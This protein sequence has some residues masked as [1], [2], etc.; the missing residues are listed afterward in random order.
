MDTRRI[1]LLVALVATVAF[2]YL[3][4][5][6]AVKDGVTVLVVISFVVLALFAFGIIGALRHP[7]ED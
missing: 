1:V 5:A 3:T 7:P 4:V 6:V 2:G